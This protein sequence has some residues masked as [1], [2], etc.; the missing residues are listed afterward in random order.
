MPAGCESSLGI[1]VRPQ[2][3]KS[4]SLREMRL[5]CDVRAPWCACAEKH[6][7]CH[8]FMTLASHSKHGMCFK[9][10]DDIETMQRIHLA[11]CVSE[12][13]YQVKTTGVNLLWAWRTMTP[14]TM[15]N[16]PLSNELKDLCHA[17]NLHM[18]HHACSGT[19]GCRPP[20]CANHDPMHE[21]CSYM[22]QTAQTHYI[23]V[24][25]YPLY[26]QISNIH[27]EDKTHM[28]RTHKNP[29]QYHPLT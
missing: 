5:L 18:S 25:T 11:L 19:H 2:H 24:T 22:T 12:V 29:S 15:T 4:L 23:T 21:N 13:T 3:S 27:Y 6:I 8:V 1:G 16:R 10:G 26:R 17:K 14:G 7:V 28:A 9:C 20:S